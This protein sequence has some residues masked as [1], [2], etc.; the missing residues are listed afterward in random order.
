VSPCRLDDLDIVKDQ[1]DDVAVS[2]AHYV[3]TEN[4][5]TQA[6]VRYLSRFDY[7]ALGEVMN[8]SYNSM[9]ESYEVSLSLSPLLFLYFLF[10]L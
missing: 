1:L 7:K 8:Q 2:R 10:L 9:K 5:R 4:S 3:I 6:A